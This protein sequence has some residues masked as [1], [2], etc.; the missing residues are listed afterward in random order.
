MNSILANLK[1]L[2]GQDDARLTNFYADLSDTEVVS[3]VEAATQESNEDDLVTTVLHDLACFRAASLTLA[4]GTLLSYSNDNY[5]DAGLWFQHASRETTERLIGRTEKREERFRLAEIAWTGS[6]LAEAQ[7]RE[8]QENTPEFIKSRFSTMNAL[9]HDAGW[10]LNQAGERY[11]LFYKE[12]RTLTWE[13]R[14]DRFN[15]GTCRACKQHLDVLFDFDLTNPT[16]NF[17]ALEG[18][19][20]RL[21]LCINCLFDD[22]DSHICFAVDTDGN[23]EWSNFNSEESRPFYS[24]VAVDTSFWR[25]NKL[26]PS[27]RTRPLLESRRWCRY[28][29]DHVGGHAG[30]MHDTDYPGCPSCNSSMKFIAQ[31]SDLNLTYAQTTR[32]VG[33]EIEGILYAFLCP[34]CM[35]STYEYQTG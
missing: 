15:S 21:P 24:D 32:Y 16:L 34:Q 10:E 11:N 2:V 1:L 30:W 27:Q 31:C 17:L 9:I 6:E 29:N 22:P 12:S 25:E 7:F 33:D 5:Y 14:E 28:A 18:T 4:H 20:L 19:R 23:Y 3:L 8:W 26:V 35:L 13:P